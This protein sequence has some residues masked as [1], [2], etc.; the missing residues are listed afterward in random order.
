MKIKVGFYDIEITAKAFDVDVTLCLL[1]DLSM[2]FGNSRKY[3]M[4]RGH[5][6]AAARDKKVSDELFDICNEAGI[7]DR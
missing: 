4:L 3:N 6:I 7:Y 2:A 5:N 1:N